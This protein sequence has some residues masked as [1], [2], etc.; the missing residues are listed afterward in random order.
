MV[1]RPTLLGGSASTGQIAREVN[2]LW[3]VN[4]GADRH[5]RPEPDDVGTEL[6]CDVPRSAEHP[7]RR[8]LFRA[9]LVDGRPA[10]AGPTARWR[11]RM[12][13]LLVADSEREEAELER[14][15][16]DAARGQPREHV[17]L[18]SPKGGVGKTTGTFIIG[19]LLAGHLK[20]RAV[21]VDANPDFGTLAALAP[22][23]RAPSARSPI[24]SRTP[25]GSTPPPS[26][27]LRLALPTG[28]HVLGAP[29]D[30]ELT[31]SLG[32]DAY[33]ELVA[34]LATFY[35][36]VLLDLGTGVAGPLARFA[37]ERADQIVLVTTP[38]WITA[39]VVLEALAHLRTT[40]RPSRSTSPTRAGPRDCESSNGA[41]ASIFTAAITI[42]YDEQLAAMLDSGTYTLEALARPTRAGDQAAR[43]RGRRTARVM[44][45]PRRAP[46]A[47]ADTGDGVGRSMV[48]S[49]RAEGRTR[50]AQGDTLA[51]HAKAGARRAPVPA[52]SAS[53]LLFTDAGAQWGPIARRRTPGS[54]PR[55]AQRQRSTRARY[56]ANAGVVWLA[57]AG[58][59]ASLTA[60]VT[61]TAAVTDPAAARVGSVTALNTSREPAATSSPGPDP[62]RLL[63]GTQVRERAFSDTP[64][65]RSRSLPRTDSETMSRGPSSLAVRATSGRLDRRSTSPRSPTVSAG[66]S[67]GGGRAVSASADGSG[68]RRLSCTIFSS[69]PT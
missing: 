25:T 44:R 2:R 49:A 56:L 20:L 26:S 46:D 62:M 55:R 18:I 53:P 8:E 41:C 23:R 11:R 16:A 47:S 17:A 37:T 21:A 67:E 36:V 45:E 39:A 14:L 27:R 3:S 24:C 68:R 10:D 19:N 4:A 42:P 48:V 1:D 65:V 34:F 57:R 32:A 63:N 60:S 7:G 29:R 13:R 64:D 52:V 22:D 9:P 69:V 6:R 59:A 50:G 31:A 54:R 35:E 51:P 28:L 12:Q 33:G 66:R 38:E 30:A 40:T 43:A 5:R 61:A 15:L 58:V